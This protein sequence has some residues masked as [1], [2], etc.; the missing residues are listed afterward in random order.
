MPNIDEHS[1]ST[2]S[3]EMFFD[4][5]FL[6]LGTGFTWNHEGTN[7]LITNWHNVTGKNPF[8]GRHIS[9]TAAE[10]NRLK[11]WFHHSGNLGDRFR[12]SLPLYDANNQPIWLVHPV[13]GNSIDVVAI[14]IPEQAEVRHFPINLMA[15]RQLITSIGIDCFILGYP[16]GIAR[17]VS[18][19]W[20]RGS[21]AIEPEFIDEN[22]RCLLVD[23]ASRPGMSGSPVILRTWGQAV[24]EDGSI[25]M[26]TG[27]STR[28]LGV[29]SGRLESTDPLDAQLGMVWPIE[30]LEQ[31]IAGQTRDS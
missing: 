23:T 17:N 26:V 6:S 3:I 10:P 19:V 13:H 21:I 24:L 18:P 29:Y 2:Y 20:K 27:T 22:D 8:T 30:Y 4:E 7:Y 16:F 12:V 28:L 14:P 11:A 15:S 25:A 9:R 1:A 5:T 31:I